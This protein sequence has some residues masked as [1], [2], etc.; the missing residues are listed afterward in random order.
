MLRL[1]SDELEA[2]LLLPKVLITAVEDAAGD[3][4]YGFENLPQQELVAALGTQLLTR[5]SLAP[6]VHSR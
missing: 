3:I 4:Q 6:L 5:L 1:D 2:S